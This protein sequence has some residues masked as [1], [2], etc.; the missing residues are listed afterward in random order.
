MCRAGNTKKISFTNIDTLLQERFRTI[1]SSYFRGASAILVAFDLTDRSTF[2][3]IGTH[4]SEIDKYANEAAVKVLVGSKSDLVSARVVSTEEGRAAM[5][6]YGFVGYFEVSAK[7]SSN[8]DQLFSETATI[9]V[10][11][12]RVTFLNILCS[13]SPTPENISLHREIAIFNPRWCQR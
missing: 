3:H 1:T 2:D 7:N 13:W 12:A 8:V 4:V 9:L 10:K 6:K 11:R 5:V